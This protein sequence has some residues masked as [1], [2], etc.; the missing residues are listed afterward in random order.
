MIPAR[1]LKN[2]PT[3]L[4][5]TYEYNGA[6]ELMREAN[7]LAQKMFSPASGPRKVNELK[8]RKVFLKRVGQVD[9]SVVIYY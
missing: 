4:S 7:G 8:T 6:N 2:L 1:I 5:V 3:P 9:Y